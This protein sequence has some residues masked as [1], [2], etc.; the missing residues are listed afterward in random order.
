MR[1]ALFVLFAIIFGLGSGNLLSQ[2]L[3]VY[4]W[5][6]PGPH[7]EDVQLRLQKTQVPISRLASINSLPMHIVFLVDVSRHQ[8]GLFSLAE[9]YIGSIAN[10]VQSP[11]VLFTVRLATKERVIIAE[12]S[13]ADGMAKA[14]DEFN[15]AQTNVSP[16]LFGGVLQALTGPD[17]R[18]V[19]ELVVISDD[20]DDIK[21]RQR[22]ILANAAAG[23]HAR[24]F[25]L[26]LAHRDFYGTHARPRSGVELNRLTDAFG[27]EQYWTNWQKRS[28]DKTILDALGKRL[29]NGTLVIFEIPKGTPV[30]PGLHHLSATLANGKS[31][32]SSKFLVTH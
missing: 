29:A 8:L 25:S 12:S 30:K 21:G 17:D 23:A 11:N 15:L 20:D 3:S 6:A 26:L 19:R 16:S 1:R 4:L 18:P 2:E 31:E 32:S 9:R 27:G 28:S 14:L 7:P 13:T 24:F 5:N 22:K 10:A